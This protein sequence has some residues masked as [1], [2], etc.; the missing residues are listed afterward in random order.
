MD[1]SQGS[2]LAAID[3]Q[4]SFAAGASIAGLLSTPHGAAP[5]PFDALD[6]KRLA[7]PSGSHPLA[8]ID[9]RVLIS[10]TTSGLVGS[11]E[12]SGPV[13]VGEGI[14]GRLR[15]QATKDIN[16]R[17]AV[18]RLLGLRL[19]EQTR[20]T[21]VKHGGG[22]D[23]SSGQISFGSSSS[24]SDQTVSW[25]E[26]HGDI[27]DTSPFTEPA[28]PAQLTAGQSI[29]LPFLVPAP[30]LGPPS[31]HAGS[32]LI[33]WALEARWDIGMGS[34]ER[35]AALVEVRQHPDLLRAGVLDLGAGAMGDSV[36]DG[37]ATIAVQPTPPVLA[38]SSIDVAIAWPGAPGGR[39]ARLELTVDVKASVGLTVVPMS[40]PI[41]LGALTST[42]VS[43]PIPVDAPPTLITNG[44]A[45]GY[46]LRVIVDR[47]LRS[48]V[49][50]ERRI[51]IC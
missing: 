4:R 49:T 20:Q 18:L 44:L 2:F 17:G 45:V 41:D 7:G 14:S 25:V 34:D 9:P 6:G 29:D 40:L 32:A 19:S 3:D 8:A 13:R 5:T 36:A 31:A 46:R 11:I 16:A 21:S 30:Q 39:S 27:F 38:G 22:I 12:L 10:P 43:L 42:H 48:D 51:V 24:G 15:V 33:A 28:I 26:I 1:P 35:M 37:G 23:L 47:K 50:A